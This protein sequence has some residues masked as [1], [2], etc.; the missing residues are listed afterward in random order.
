LSRF[1]EPVKQNS[2][3]RQAPG[4]ADRVVSLRAR[5]V[6]RPWWPQPLQER[7]VA[8]RPDRLPL[9]RRRARL[10]LPELRQGHRQLDVHRL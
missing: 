8:R 9:P 10:A 3:K 7:L 5:L 4:P 6:Q 1:N 2:P